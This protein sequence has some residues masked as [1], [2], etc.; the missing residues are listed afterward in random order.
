MY[1]VRPSATPEEVTI[2][3]LAPCSGSLPW[4]VSIMMVSITTIT[5]ITTTPTITMTIT[6]TITI[7]IPSTHVEDGLDKVVASNRRRGQFA[8]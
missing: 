7:T 2:P 5:I 8:S 6:I 3:L 1:V 4:A